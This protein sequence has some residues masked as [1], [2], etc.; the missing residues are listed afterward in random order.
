M[1]QGKLETEEKEKELNVL[2]VSA[3]GI[4]PAHRTISEEHET[5][6]KN[7]ESS[8]SGNYRSSSTMLIT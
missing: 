2:K 6:Q 1:R 5:E 3:S 8:P 7:M 4:V